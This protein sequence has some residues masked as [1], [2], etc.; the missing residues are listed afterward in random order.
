MP[1]SFKWPRFCRCCL[2]V[3]GTICGA[4]AIARLLLQRPS[5]DNVLDA[6]RDALSARTGAV[7]YGR[8]GCGRPLY[9]YAF[10][11][12]SC[13]MVLTF[14]AHGYEDA[15]PADGGALVLTACRLMDV[16]AA[17]EAALTEAD[18]TVWVLPCLNPDGLFDGVSNNG[19]GRCTVASLDLDGTP[20]MSG[21]DL[22]RCFPEQW[23]KQDTSRN[24]NGDAPLACSEAVAL[25]SFL[26][27]VFRAERSVCIDVHG[28]YG[29]TITSDSP[30]D[31]LFRAFRT[32]FPD[33][34]WADCRNGGGYLT[35]YAAALG[36]DACL[37]EFPGSVHSLDAFLAGDCIDRFL[38]C[39]RLLLSV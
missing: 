16:L 15:F 25:A 32:Q 6:V 18:W 35:A 38:R 37:F 10:G 17:S 23:E 19:P 24:A 9:A 20:Q 4:F 2:L 13:V 26:Q 39:I 33:N 8:S 21:V 14:A 28:W 12:G 27:T 22:N 1:H 34:T 5:A 3:L 31:W 7:E 11:S 29:Q 36:Y 30:D